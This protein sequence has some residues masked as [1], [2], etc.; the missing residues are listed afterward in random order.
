M[1]LSN[2]LLVIMEITAAE[3]NTNT[4]NGTDILKACNFFLIFDISFGINKYE[5]Q[6]DYGFYFTRGICQIII[7]KFFIYEI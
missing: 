1:L 6:Y 7:I 4:N 3:Y 2:F 5:L